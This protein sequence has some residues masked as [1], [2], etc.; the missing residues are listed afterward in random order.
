MAMAMAAIA[1][2]VEMSRGCW[3]EPVAATVAVTSLVSQVSRG[4][5]GSGW[6]A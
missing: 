3:D 4:S 2:D 6:C 1:R 5:V